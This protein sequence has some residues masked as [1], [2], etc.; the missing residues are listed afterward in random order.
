MPSLLRIT[1]MFYL[2]LC[3]AACCLQD[4]LLF[5]GH[6]HQG[7]PEAIIHPVPGAEVVHLTSAGGDHV[8]AIYGPALLPDGTTDPSAAHRPTL[9]YFYANASAIAWSMGEFDHF[10]RLD[11]NVLIPDFVGYGMSSGKPT[12][13]TLYATADAAYDYLLHRPDVDSH[14]IVVVGWSLGTAVAI[15]LASRKSLA[16]L[17]TFNAFTN[18]HEV[19]HREFPW[20]PTGA[21]LKYQFDNEGKIAKVTCPIFICNGM[22]DTLVPPAMSDR[23]TAAAC[24]P[25]TRLRIAS[26][27]HYNI[28]TAVHDEPFSSLGEFIRDIGEQKP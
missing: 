4:T 5:P 22:R 20:L 1:F 24:G 10:R 11:A 19:A 26:A 7:K 15:D 27:D 25:V 3:A 13:A 9:I 16:G 18:I 2:I 6:A 28:F 23:L 14:K 17:A 21:I 12:E 8:A